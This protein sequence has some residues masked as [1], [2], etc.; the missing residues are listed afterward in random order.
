M[1][2]VKDSKWFYWD[3][4]PDAFILPYFSHPIKWYGIF[5]ALGFM[6]AYVILVRVFRWQL[7]RTSSQTPTAIDDLSHLLSEKV[8]WFIILGTLVGAR[9]GHVFFYDWPYYKNHLS[10][11][12]QVWKGGLA[13][14]VGVLGIIVSLAL[15]RWRIKSLAPS[16]T[17]LLLLDS[18]SIVCGIPAAFIRIG[19]FINQEILGTV[20]DLPWAVV[21]GHPVDGSDPIPRHPV[22]LYESIYYFFVF[23]GMVYLWK[24]HKADKMAPGVLTGI[25]LVAIFGFRIFIELFK[26]PQGMLINQEATFDMGQYLSIPLV[27]FGAY[28][29]CRG[30]VADSPKVI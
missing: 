23:C 25:L 24:S 4:S 21:F 11:I 6:A 13:S 29:L 20:T 1:D 14:H 10:D 7:N 12:P 5:F 15:F 17:F 27:C 16:L 2:F 26:A 8:L 19:N 18:I 28:L 22:Q 3:P 30:K 9:L